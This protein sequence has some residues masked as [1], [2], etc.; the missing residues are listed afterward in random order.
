MAVVVV[1]VRRTVQVA[2]AVKDNL[3]ETVEAQAPEA[4]GESVGKVA[5]IPT[6]P[7]TVVMAVAA[8]LIRLALVATAATKAAVVVELWVMP[9]ARTVIRSP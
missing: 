6:I 1:V 8:E 4:L 5:E 7:P 3:R 2:P 9:F